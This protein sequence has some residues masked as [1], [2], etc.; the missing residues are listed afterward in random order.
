MN[1]ATDSLPC[2]VATF[3]PDGVILDMNRALRTLI[4]LPDE[5]GPSNFAELLTL[6][7]RIF[8]QTHVFPLLRAKGAIEEIYLDL[9]GPDGT[10][11]PVMVN[12][13]LNER[14]GKT[15]VHAV[16]LAMRRR[17]Q[18]EDEILRARRESQAA[19]ERLQAY[20][21]ELENLRQDLET[22]VELRTQ[23]LSQANEELRGFIYSIV[24]DL[25]APLRAIDSTS[26]ILLTE[27]SEG[28]S[29]DQRFLLGRQAHNVR[30]LH[31]LIEGLLNY[32]RLGQK[33][34]VKRPI[35]LSKL[36]GD[37][38][39]VLRQGGQHPDVWFEIAPDLEASADIDAMRVV[40]TNLLDNAA[41]YSPDGGRVTVGQKD[42]AY[43]VRDEGIG[44]DM[45]YIDKIF[46][47][48]ERLHRDAE[49]QGT[50]IGLANVKRIVE[51]HG[52]RVW[53]ESTPGTGA[54]FYF[55]LG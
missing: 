22:R 48:F 43:F 25:G 5:G 29:E 27:D 33:S 6:P 28:L 7:S 21:S 26:A 41:K 19:Q 46:L 51:R 16:L 1:E 47:P 32:A 53:A 42:E 3:L 20:S 23:E 40:M 50:G 34:I 4:D 13:C 55:T 17:S 30:R 8:C 15:V 35:D 38:V 49:F 45:V 54:T 44:F 52:G 36:A 14:D 10:Q 24:H 12:A 9:R 39:R 31:A 2:G 11:I 18:Y 37:I